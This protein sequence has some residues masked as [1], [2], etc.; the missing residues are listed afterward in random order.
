MGSNSRSGRLETTWACLQVFHSSSYCPGVAVWERRNLSL[1][2]DFHSSSY[3]PWKFEK[4]ETS[5][6]P[7][8]STP[9][10]TAHGS[11]RKEKPQPVPSLPLLELLPMVVWERRNL[12]FPS[13]PLLELLPMEVWERRNLSLSQ[14]FHSSSYSPMVVWER[15]NLS[16]SQTSTPR[17]TAEEWKLLPEKGETSVCPSS[18]PRVT[19]H[20]SLR[21][22]KP[23]LSQ[24]STPR[25]TA[26]GSLRK[27]KPQ[28]VPSLL[29]LPWAVTAHSLR[30]EKP[31]PVPRLPLLELLPMV[32][33]ERSNSGVEVFH[34]WGFP[35][36]RLP[37]L[38]LLPMVVW[39]WKP[40]SSCPW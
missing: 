30:K 4:G 35:F 40:Q 6:C 31:Q 13:L 19:A 29:K 23:L 37:L 27:E 12:S 39:E 18:T 16:L 24:T 22:E 15:R 1:S 5:A 28:S 2:Q 33:W 32:V 26:H 10:V 36:L 7:K 14:D 34:S 21:K 8:S 38:E 20:G 17:V 9:R 3:C 25:V 11:L